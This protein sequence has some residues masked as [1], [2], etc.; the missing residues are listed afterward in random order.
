MKKRKVM[1]KKQEKMKKKKK[2]KE[3]RRM[4]KWLAIIWF[5]GAVQNLSGWIKLLD[6]TFPYNKRVWRDLAKMQWQAKNH[7][8]RECVLMRPPPPGEEEASKPDKGKKRKKEASIESLKSKKPK[9]RRPQTDATVLTSTATASLRTEEKDNDDG[10]LPL[11]QIVR[12]STYAPQVIRR[13]A[14]ELGMSNV[15]QYRA[16]E[17]LEEGL[18][19]VPEPQVGHDLNAPVA[20]EEA[21]RLQKQVKKLYDHAF[22]KLQDELSCREKDLEKLTSKLNESKASSSRKEEE[23]S[24]LWTSLEG[25]GKKNAPVEQLQ[26]EVATKDVEILE[27]KRQKEVVTSE[28]D[29]LRGELASTQDLLRRAQKEAT[30]LSVAKSEADEYMSSNK[31]DAATTN[32]RAREIS[33][34]V[35]QKLAW[36]V[37]HAHLQARRQAFEEASTKGVDLS[38]EI[39][40]ARVLEEE[41]APSTTSDEGSESDSGNTEGEE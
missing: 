15:D 12:R 4:K 18:G 19:A 10:D 9:V 32:D 28:K 7:G 6:S 1:K 26:E 21:E 16:E 20:L 34:N 40:K 41:S 27:L 38:A 29:F 37:S 39:E 35:E 14:S 5:P 17:T 8:L 31:R 11:V 13:K 36:A 3:R 23:L 2:M 25:I 30:T 33:E 24:E 22:S